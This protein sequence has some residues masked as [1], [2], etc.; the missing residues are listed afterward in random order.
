MRKAQEEC[1]TFFETKPLE[2]DTV[3]AGTLDSNPDGP[4]VGVLVEPSSVEGRAC[5]GYSGSVHLGMIMRVFKAAGIPYT[6]IDIC[7]AEKQGLPD[8]DKV[9][10]IVVCSGGF[11]CSQAP[12]K[13][14]SDAGGKFLWIGGIEPGVLG[15]L[16]GGLKPLNSEDCPGVYEARRP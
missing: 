4:A 6:P 2:H 14:Y 5:F 10:A 12:F 8:P 7:R 16:S 3:Y 1:K 9:P 13:K 11:Y 15:K